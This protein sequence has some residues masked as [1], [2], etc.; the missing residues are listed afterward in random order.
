MKPI[1]IKAENMGST[2]PIG[3][4][5]TWRT[6]HQVTYYVVDCIEHGYD[7][8]VVFIGSYQVRWS[9]QNNGKYCVSLY[10]KARMMKSVYDN[11]I[12][13][14]ENLAYMILLDHDFTKFMEE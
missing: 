5:N 3:T 7:Y 6:G 1:K 9:L 4:V 13:Q 10:R 11:T 12:R 14:A 8:I 2:H